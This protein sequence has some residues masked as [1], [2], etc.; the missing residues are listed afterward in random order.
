MKPFL[1]SPYAFLVCA[2]VILVVVDVYAIPESFAFMDL[3]PNPYLV[4]SVVLAAFYGLRVALVSSLAASVVYLFSVHLNLNYQVVETLFDFEYLSIP[5]L[6]TVISVIIGELKQRSLNHIQNLEVALD[7]QKKIQQHLSGK[8]STQ[9]KEIAELKKR[10][11]SK[12]DTARSFYDVATSFQSI[13]EDT[14]LENFQKALVR[15]FKTKEVSVYRVLEEKSTLQLWH[16]S[17]ELAFEGMDAL[18]KESLRTKK[19]TSLQD[20]YSLKMYTHGKNE[21]LLAIPIMVN[22]RI[23]FLARISGISFLDYIPSN[24]K[25]SELYT[26]WL[27]SS[28]VYGRNYLNSM[29]SNVWNDQL[30]VYQHRYFEERISEE[31]NRSKAY[32]LPLTLIKFTIDSLDGL[33]GS[34]VHAIKKI[35]SGLLSHSIRKL[36]YITEGKGDNEFL[37]VLPIFDAAG[38]QEV[39]KVV[40]E[41]FRKLNLQGPGRAVQLK[42][43][44]REF[45]PSMNG[46][47]DF[48]GGLV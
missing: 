18:T 47:E 4:L 19:Q 39:E 31:F 20:V 13:E 1:R 2:L 26:E 11:V 7:D 48:T 24:F 35:L 10:L 34:R 17:E 6:L 33:P 44:I 37:V 45:D 5:I 12:L 16:G 23:E 9:E 42:S 15:L 43:S 21:T 40:S 22:G 29:K 32:M 27:G 38:A 8:E 25:I 41:K 3:N 46:V 28:L 36:D 14:L 30:Q